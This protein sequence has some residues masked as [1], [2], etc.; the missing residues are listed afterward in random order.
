MNSPVTNSGPRV[1]QQ[2]RPQHAR[3]I[4]RVLNAPEDSAVVVQT[5]AGL[6][7][8]PKK[9]FQSNIVHWDV[10]SSLHDVKPAVVCDNDVQ[11]LTIDG[12]A[13]YHYGT[14]NQGV[15]YGYGYVDGVLPNEGRYWLLLS[16]AA[17][18]TNSVA[19]HFV[20]KNDE[21]FLEIAFQD[22]AVT[23]E[24]TKHTVREDRRFTLPTSRSF[25]LVCI[26][27]DASRVDVYDSKKKLIGYSYNG[28]F[29]QS[30]MVTVLSSTYRNLNNYGKIS[31]LATDTPCDIPADYAPLVVR[32]CKIEDPYI[33]HFL[34]P[35]GFTRYG[36]TAV[37]PTK[38]Y[39]SDEKELIVLNEAS[40]TASLIHANHFSEEQYFYKDV[41]FSGGYR[42]KTSE[43]GSLFF[44]NDNDVNALT[45]D[46]P[47]SGW[48]LAFGD[49][50]WANVGTGTYT[51]LV[52]QELGGRLS[53]SD[54]T[55]VV[56][57]GWN[58]LQVASGLT[59]FGHSN[60]RK[61]E[62]ANQ[63][64]I[65]GNRN[66]G[67][68]V[69]TFRSAV[70]IGEGSFNPTSVIAD[71]EH[72]TVVG[73]NSLNGSV[74]GPAN[75]VIGNAAATAA[76]EELTVSDNVVIGYE[77]LAGHVGDVDCSVVV[78]KEAG[79][80]VGTVNNSVLVG[81]QSGRETI[82]N[83]IVAVGA[84]ALDNKDGYDLPNF[85]ATAIGYKSMQGQSGIRNST[86][87]GAGSRVYGDDQV[88]LGNT[89]TTV[90]SHVANSVRADSRDM[91]FVQRTSLGLDF[92]LR[93]RPVEY[94]TNFR[95]RNRE[96][97]NRPQPPQPP[98]PR[99]SAP[100]ISPQD[101]A[102]Q[103]ELLSY[104]EDEQL[105]QQEYETYQI[106]QARW[107]EEV[108]R[109]DSEN[110]L[111]AIKVDPEHADDIVHQ[112][113]VGQELEALMGELGIDSALLSKLATQTGDSVMCVSYEQLVPPL[114]N[115][116]QE[117]TKEVRSD[118]FASRVAAKVLEMI[119]S[120]R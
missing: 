73:N 67:E 27:I 64:T 11:K 39:Y 26:D 77:A 119:R 81:E 57:T 53:Y 65:I 42:L 29:F 110:A 79:K 97:Q 70:V 6:R 17:A 1:P 13:F 18:E 56:G 74:V 82:G 59:S 80:G 75:V 52:G 8:V 19:Y 120:T 15:Q 50:V 36:M 98:R 99:P 45:L 111:D 21:V 47:E 40:T 112:G 71:A 28:D 105:W 114:I 76:A 38:L 46:R 62:V 44:G 90:F 31:T 49:N 48:I 84:N 22:R 33:R 20:D 4:P 96:Y 16:A 72:S 66:V 87:I 3:D 51:I 109:W 5:E 55:T 93:I 89:E 94:R 54:L 115:A 100:T 116:V 9:R 102:Y 78:G 24:S 95:D 63:V 43:Q 85:D 23:I 68:Q 113:I 2:L 25:I 88:W 32:K 34:K 86:A 117:L 83:G 91:S 35:T 10:N 60:A 14:G 69:R 106:E 107:V 58:D 101:P 41:I 104:R 12:D 103:A 37:V 92:I 30:A 7:S 108:R 118:A 61:L